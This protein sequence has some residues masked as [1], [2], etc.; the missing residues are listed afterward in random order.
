[1]R[2]GESIT[3]SL[4]VKN[5]SARAGTEIVQWYIR[6]L[7]GSVVRPVMELKGFERV[8]LAPG[9]TK[10][11]RFTVTDADLQFYGQ[12]MRL[13]SEPGAFLLMAGP[14]SGELQ[15]VRFELTD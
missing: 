3:A 6:D 11:L 1:M 4:T 9:E 10:T 15:S 5:T 2:R 12:D 8:T 14:H 7:V 13:L